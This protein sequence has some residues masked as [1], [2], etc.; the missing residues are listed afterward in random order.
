MSL[1]PTF[2]I[3]ILTSYS[4]FSSDPNNSF[5]CEGGIDFVRALNRIGGH[6]IT[7][8]NHK[9]L[10]ELNG[11]NETMR[12]IDESLCE[13]KVDIV[14]FGLDA[15]FYF[16]LEYFSRLGSSYFTVMV[17]GD[18]EHYFDKSARYYSQA[19]D[20]VMPGGWLSE[21][22][23]KLYGVDTI[24]FFNADYNVTSFKDSNKDSDTDK[25]YDVCFVGAVD[26][27]VGRKEYLAHLIK[28]KI[29]VKV[30]GPGTVEG[31]VTRDEM[32]RIYRSSRIGL[33]FSGVSFD[34]ALD[35]DITINRRIKHIKG[36]DREITLLGT[37]MLA[38]YS[39]ELE[40]IY[41]VG[42]EIDIF[43]N[44][45]ELLE[46]VKYY[47]E[48]DALREEM[49]S[50]GY[51]KAIREG[52]EVESWK[53]YLALISKKVKEKNMSGVESENIIYKDP[54]FLRSFA[55]FHLFKMLVFLASLKLKLAF[56]EFVIWVKY[57]L[58]DSGVFRWYVK[59]QTVGSLGGVKWLRKLVRAIKKRL[60][61]NANKI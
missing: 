44:K 11:P 28:N 2:S 54:I 49:A 39:Y 32:A 31:K 9:E 34:S 20:L 48:N 38:E 10:Y 41:D 1:N 27:K 24:P 36:R 30:C 35:K 5:E 58:F 7:C 14:I 21:Q 60:K 12:I 40:E 53:K 47:L 50:R 56:H 42:G 6:R 18:D 33:S 16:P 3:A 37:F 29:N 17:V 15:N 4:E 19:F 25:I 46:K 26:N 45:E 51:E 43:R 61:G 57:P 23:Y 8:L 13:N 22:R 52:D 59:N 55:A